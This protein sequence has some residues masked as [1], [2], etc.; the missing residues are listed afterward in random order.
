MRNHNLILS[1][2]DIWSSDSNKSFL[3]LTVH[4]IYEAKLISLTLSTSEMSSNHTAEHIA[5][6]I[7]EILE[8]QWKIYDKVV[9]IVIDNA[10]N[11]KKAVSEYLNKCIKIY[12][13]RIDSIDQLI[14]RDQLDSMANLNVVYKISCDDCEASYAGQTKRKLKTR[15]KEHVSDIRKKTGSPSVISDHHINYNHNFNWE[16]VKILYREPSY[17]KSLVNL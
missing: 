13:R 8:N 16:D 17:N 5:M 7:R 3:T 6:T 10:A 4:F 14:T 12:C 2:S 9:T 11:V 15:V 1:Q